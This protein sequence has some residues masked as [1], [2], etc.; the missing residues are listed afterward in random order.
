MNLV[1]TTGTTINFTRKFVWHGQEKIE[2]RDAT[3]AVTQRNFAQGQYVGT[4]AY[5]Y[6]R[7]H[8]GS[9]REMFS[10][11]GTVVARYDYDPYGRSTTVLGTTPTDF[12][13]TG[14]YRHSKS[15]LDLATYRAYDPDL[16]R[17]LSRDP[18]AE[19]GG[20]NLY[21]YGG[22]NPINSFDPLGLRD[23]YVAIWN[24]HQ[25][26][27]WGQGSVGHVAI[28]EMNGATLLSQFPDPHGMNGANIF[29][30]YS[31][32]VKN[33]EGGRLP[34][35]VFKVF[36]PNDDAFDKELKEIKNY[37]AWNWMPDAKKGQT[38]CVKGAA[39]ALNAGGVPVPTYNMPSDFGRM[40]DAWKNKGGTQRS[41]WKITPVS[42]DSIPMGK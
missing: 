22:S 38:N 7:D 39:Q 19:D 29:V 28:T 33:R 36:V 25:P 26:Y 40:L 15:N 31:D 10:G 4:T 12:N 17:W 30:P 6:T 32:V 1:E 41:P 37:D 42:S 9:I 8:L 35:L 3:D 23:V 24:G 27:L 18:L 13:F 14:L 11:G 34:D 21:R 5:F 16:G 20:L 2:F